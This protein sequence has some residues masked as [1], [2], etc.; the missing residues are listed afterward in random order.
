MTGFIFTSFEHLQ[1]STAILL[2]KTS[3]TQSDWMENICEHQFLGLATDSQ[4]DLGL[5][6][7]YAILTHEYLIETIRCRSHCCL[8]EGE[9]P[10]QAFFQDCPGFGSIDE[11]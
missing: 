2:C 10:H 5:D 3:Q 1:K 6:F 8:L 11:A 4:L 7:D 9:P